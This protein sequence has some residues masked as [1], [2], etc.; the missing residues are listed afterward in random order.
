MIR[1][2]RLGFVV[3]GAVLLQTTVFTHLRID[4]VAPEVGLVCVLA[5]A[6]EDGA[7]SG[8]IFGFVMGLSMDLFSPTPLGLLALTY[9]ITGYAVGVF[10]AGS[11]AARRSSPRSSAASAAC[12]AAWCSS[13]SAPWS[14]E[15]GFLSMASIKTVLI[16][17]L[18]DA[19]IAPLVFPVVRRAAREPEGSGLRDWR[20]LRARRNG[21]AHAVRGRLARAPGDRR[22]D[23]RRAV[24]RAARRGS[25]SSRSP[26]ARQLAVAAQR[27][28]DHTVSVPALPRRHP[29]RQGPRA[30]RDGRHVVAHRR[31]PG[32]HGRPAQGPRGAARVLP[33]AGPGG[34]RAAPRLDAVRA[35]RGGAGRRAHRR[36]TS[37]C[38]SRSTAREFPHTQ[39]AT[40]PVRVYPYGA[41]AAHVV[42]LPRPDQRGRAEGATRRG[43]RARR[44]DRQGR[45]RAHVRV[46]AARHSRAST[47]CRSTAAGRPPRSKATRQPVAGHDVQLSIDLDAQGIAEESLQQGIDGAARHV[48][49]GRPVATTSRR[50]A[51]S[52]CSTPAPASS[53]RWRRR[54]R[55][56]PTR[57]STARPTSTSP[58]P[59]TR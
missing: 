24:H 25:G 28:R 44:H 52:S 29:R 2:I 53:S 51:R 7:D 23:R 55:S 5:V 32:A 20:S 37:S 8:A 19:L 36:R 21:L 50:A 26:G 40:T 31:P 34:D 54:R 16:A 38:T 57:S 10:Q 3:L 56:T 45:H 17:A 43:L 30:G 42:G 39:L 46:G 59:R 4:G 13:R 35:L 15:S 9:A 22:R 47:P 1:R 18:Y 12:S 41:A 33:R 27:Q 49:Q 48:G 11:C 6:Y 58:T 14:G